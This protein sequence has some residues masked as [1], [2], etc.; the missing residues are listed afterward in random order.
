[1]AAVSTSEVVQSALQPGGSGKP[2]VLTQPLCLLPGHYFATQSGAG[3]NEQ[4]GPKRRKRIIQQELRPR[5][6][7]H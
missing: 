2:L 5:R 1:M 4:S 7:P 6:L 3:F